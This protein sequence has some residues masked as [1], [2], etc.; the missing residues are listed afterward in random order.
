[1]ENKKVMHL[2]GRVVSTRPRAR[3]KRS[4]GL[5]GIG[6]GGVETTPPISLWLRPKVAL[7]NQS[8]SV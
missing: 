1:M 5:A 7:D 8:V 4:W 2:M 6:L 3:R